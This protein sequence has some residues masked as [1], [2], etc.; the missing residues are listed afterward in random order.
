MMRVS[1]IM[2]YDAG[3]DP[4]SDRPERPTA[5]PPSHLGS[6]GSSSS[7]AGGPKKKARLTG[8]DIEEDIEEEENEEKEGEEEVSVREI[9]SYL[10]SDD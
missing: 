8:D 9:G 5:S 4:G 6:G 1:E 7:S 3:A 10:P 2:E